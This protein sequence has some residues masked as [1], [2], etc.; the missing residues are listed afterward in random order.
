M[1]STEDTPKENK[2]DFLQRQSWQ[3][4]LII[5][6]FALAGM[7][8]GA[9]KFHELILYLQDISQ[10]F[11]YI[12]PA[13]VFILWGINLA[14]F[15]TILHF[16]MNVVLR[17]LWIGGLALRGT[18]NKKAYLNDD[19]APNFARY[20]H[21]RH[22]SFDR[23][24]ER[25]DKAASLVFAF[26]FLLVAILFGIIF[27]L[28]VYMG[29]FAVLAT[30]FDTI[31]AQIASALF[32]L[33]ILVGFLY[34]SDFLTAGAF[35]RGGEAFYFPIYRAMGWLT[36]ARLYRPLYYAVIS[37]K[38]GK[39]LILAM[40]PYILL[41]VLIPRQTLDPIPYISRVDFIS[42]NDMKTVR[43]ARLYA[44]AEGFR[45]TAT[46]IYIDT[47]VVTDK[48]LRVHLPLRESYAEEIA[49]MAEQNQPKPA[50]KDT[51]SANLYAAQDTVLS[52]QDSAAQV[53]S[54]KEARRLK[55][56]AS[57]R[58]TGMN[59]RRWISG[60]LPLSELE[61]NADSLLI[62]NF[63]SIMEL[64]LDGKPVD[65][66]NVLLSVSYRGSPISELVAYFPLHEKA[67]GMHRLEFK[68]FS[69]DT[70]GENKGSINLRDTYWVP[71]FYAPEDGSAAP[72]PASPPMPL[73]A[74]DEQTQSQ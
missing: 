14:Y 10:Q 7:I 61:G 55:L 11:D 30:A 39:R 56:E 51:S 49:L 69:L 70:R 31:G 12:G 17:C 65:L 4:E 8:S 24:V 53:A 73:P 46:S 62:A 34:L 57:S 59:A 66:D 37:N 19:Y 40:V 50:I 33:Y 6:G 27:Y 15:L 67:P 18:M 28:L 20:L 60:D 68:V 52:P 26:T 23:Y 1:L 43:K 58:R 64:R 3:L 5:T 47:D 71:F 2:L 29:F 63:F 44:D 54:R 9:S 16:F 42:N 22:G 21:R 32:L 45:P 41:L 72:T 74:P 25:L 35:K 13:A 36:L 48:V 38:W